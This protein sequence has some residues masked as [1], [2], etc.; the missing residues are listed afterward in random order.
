MSE[1]KSPEIEG[2][3]DDEEDE[4]QLCVICLDQV[5]ICGLDLLVLCCDCMQCFDCVKPTLL[6]T[7]YSFMLNKQYCILSKNVSLWYHVVICVAASP[8]E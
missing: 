5:S 3:E 4:D 1:E 2:G 8:V 6:P 7:L